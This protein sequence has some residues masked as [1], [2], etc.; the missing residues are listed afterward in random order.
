MTLIVWNARGLCTSERQNELRRMCQERSTEIFGALKTKTKIDKFKD[1]SERMGEEW[2][3]VR[4]KDDSS[5]DSIWFGWNSCNW[6]ATILAT[7]DQYIHARMKNIGGYE[8]DLTIVYGESTAVKRR[9][10]W[11]GIGAIRPMSDAKDWMMIGDFNEIRHP[12]EREGHDSFDRSGA[13]EFE[14]AIAG[15][16]ELEAIGSRF[17]WS[18]GVG[19]QHTRSHLDRALGNPG[20][21]VRWAHTRPRLIMGTSSDPYGQS[22]RK[23][24]LQKVYG[25][26]K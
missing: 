25:R 2:K 24:N 16:T 14:T 5:R 21:I 19:S 17:T 1:A 12:V 13:D 23:M 15:F 4:N 8:F 9:P 18:N 6:N 26:I 3:I 10:L 7:H 22:F 20:R 11:S